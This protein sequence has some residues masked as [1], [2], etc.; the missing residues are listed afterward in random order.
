MTQYNVQF[1]DGNGPLAGLRN[2]LINGGMQISQRGQSTAY[3]ANS[4]TYVADRWIAFSSSSQ[5]ISVQDNT[6]TP[7]GLNLDIPSGATLITALELE[8]PG[9]TA[10]FYGT[11][12]FS[13]LSTTAPTANANFEYR[14]T[15][16]SS[17]NQVVIGTAAMTA[18]GESYGSFNEYS[19]QIT[20]GGVSPVATNL[21]LY[22]DIGLNTASTSVTGFQLEPGPVAT[23]F[24]Q[25]PTGLELSLCQRYYQLVDGTGGPVTAYAT[26][27]DNSSGGQA[28]RF[29]QQ[30]LTTSM[31][32][33]PTVTHGT[34][35]NWGTGP[36]F[37]DSSSTFLA[38]QGTSGVET[39][40]TTI[41]DVVLDAEL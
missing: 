8:T 9:K 1:Q 41:Q 31:R 28:S 19:G 16:T 37:S 30:M 21:C 18:T 20:F 17:T 36:V 27:T 7:T 15:S 6:V 26:I 39:S 32:T 24:E 33:A 10:P 35:T 12:T 29:W 2:Q 38:V 23:P 13:F 14:D 40:V 3:T 25:R 11:W 4:L 22:I 5:T 34:A